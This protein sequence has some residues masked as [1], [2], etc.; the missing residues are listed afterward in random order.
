MNENTLNEPKLP[1]NEQIL[2]V[3]N[4]LRYKNLVKTQRDFATFLEMN[5]QTIS[6]AMRGREGYATERTLSRIDKVLQDKCAVSIEEIC[7]GVRI[8]NNGTNN[9]QGDQKILGTQDAEKIV[10]TLTQE[11]AA[12]RE[13][14]AAQ[15]ERLFNML[16]REQNKTA[17]LI[18][19]LQ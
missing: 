13:Q 14:Y 4:Y 16:E 2:C 10:Q 17:E 12:Q 19:H 5:E 6:A 11:M 1:Q 8:I 15:F 7:G 9:V 18:K 3:F